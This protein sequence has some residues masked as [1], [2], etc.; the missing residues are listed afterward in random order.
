MFIRKSSFFFLVAFSVYSF[1]QT[2]S[3]N[4]LLLEGQSLFRKGDYSGS[5]EKY[6]NALSLP[7]TDSEQ[8]ST[9]RKN[10]ALSAL[11]AGQNDT[12]SSLYQTVPGPEGSYGLGISLFRQAEESEKE[13]ATNA[14]LRA[15]NAKKTADLFGKASDS[16]RAAIQGGMT[17]KIAQTNL[18]TALMK[19]KEW[20]QKAKEANLEVQYGEKTPSELLNLLMDEQKKSYVDGIVGVTN[21]VSSKIKQFEKAANE[22]RIVADIWPFLEKEILS[23]AR[24]QITNEEQLAELQKQFVFSRDRADGS[25]SALE[26]LNQNA[27]SS[28]R[29]NNMDA[30]LVFSMISDPLQL[31]TES[32]STESNAL[33]RV[34]DYQ[35]FRVPM[36]EQGV[37]KGLF[38]VF[39]QKLPDWLEQKRQQNSISTENQQSDSVL[40]EEDMEELDRLIQQV[41]NAFETISKEICQTD[42]ILPDS[43]VPA[44][45]QAQQ[46]MIAIKKILEKTQPP[47]ENQ[48]NQQN[49]QDKKQNEKNDSKQNQENQK[50]NGQD[51]QNEQ[52]S[53]SAEE[54]SSQPE[55]EVEKQPEEKTQQDPEERAANE[56]MNAILK[57]EKQREEEKNK[58]RFV[59]PAKVGE[60]DW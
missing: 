4:D 51:Q 56:M 52:E 60:K 6:Q 15:K 30:L 55:K 2:E 27:F 9:I 32:I 1:G 8:L 29:E 36:E 45:Q 43:S 46:D 40:T 7:N 25:F 39:Q 57:L 49:E 20:F 18:V 10:A 3:I 48:Q 53:Q 13:P 17:E 44:G 59:L 33:E 38:S 24:N 35:K 54:N 22:Q 28:M 58:K 12:A 34:V 21:N 37:V 31:I 11:S 5:L 19:S 14:V 42:R 41:N 47:Q 26:E 23:Q 16:F 50:Q